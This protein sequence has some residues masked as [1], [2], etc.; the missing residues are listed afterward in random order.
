MY[1]NF[2]MMKKALLSI[3]FLILLSAAC[4][5]D[6]PLTP[7]RVY[8]TEKV[9]LIVIDGPRYTDIN[10]DSALA[11]LPEWSALLAKGKLH[12]EIYNTGATN[13]INGLSHLTTGIYGALGNT[14]SD[15]PKNKTIFHSYLQ[16]FNINSNKAAIFSSKDKVGVLQK[17]GNGIPPYADC[18]AIGGGY[19]S[20]SITLALAQNYVTAQSP[21]LILVHFAE[22]D[23]S[24]H[25][26]NF[27]NYKKAIATSTK[28]AADLYNSFE[29]NPMY[30]GK[31]TYLFANDHGRHTTDFTGH[32][33][34]CNGCRHLF[35]LA[36]GPDTKCGSSSN[37]AS[38][39]DIAS[40]IA[41]ILHLK[42][43]KGNGRILE[44]VLQ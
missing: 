39:I 38:Q 2:L 17:A 14:G 11:D 42:T 43:F 27:I 5:R 30:T 21:N 36:I 37:K 35:L 20:D 19:R 7:P 13:T 44:E 22:P 15:T 10:S 24:G 3:G 34:G 4:R 28:N 32:G 23:V 29:T 9:V 16:D 6:T 41:E 8:K 33:D 31:T 12:T 26:G 25:A 40:T 1:L 18:G